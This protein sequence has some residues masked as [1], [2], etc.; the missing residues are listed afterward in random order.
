MLKIKLLLATFVLVILCGCTQNNTGYESVQDKLMNME[1]YRAS[2]EI[3]YFNKDGDNTYRA[4]QTADR[5]GR[6]KLVTYYPEKFKDCAILFDGKMIWQYNPNVEQK[7]S[8][9]AEDKPERSELNLFAFIQNYVKSSD[10][11][12]KTASVKNDTGKAECTVL[13]ATIGTQNK[14]LADEKLWVNNEDATP[15]KLVIYDSDGNERV[16]L[17][18]DEFEYNPELAGD[19]FVPNN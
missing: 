2:V 18:F 5:S 17:K 4:V 13:E 14:F 11:T 9:V 15:Q 1:S 7:I 3:N 10:G 6:Y 12:V 19:E 16:E 8:I